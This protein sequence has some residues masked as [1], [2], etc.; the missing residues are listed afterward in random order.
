MLTFST[1]RRE[2]QPRN[3]LLWKVV[4]DKVVQKRKIYLHYFAQI[5]SA[6]GR[7]EPAKNVQKSHFLLTFKPLNLLRNAFFRNAACDKY[8]QRRKLNI[9]R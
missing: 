7:Q 2:G 4:T 1:F 8:A 5:L 3:A 6:T 9:S